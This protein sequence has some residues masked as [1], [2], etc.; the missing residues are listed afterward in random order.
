MVDDVVKQVSGEDKKV[1]GVGFCWGAFIL[2]HAQKAGVKLTGCVCLHPSLGI[3][4]MQGR[5]HSELLKA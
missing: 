4:D 1:V 5:S 2:Y 3:E